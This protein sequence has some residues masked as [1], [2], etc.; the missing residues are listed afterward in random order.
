[1]GG[2]S[3]FIRPHAPRRT[4]LASPSIT[5]RWSNKWCLAAPRRE[6]WT[7]PQ[8]SDENAQK[9]KIKNEQ[10]PKTGAARL[11]S[12]IVRS[13]DSELRKKTSNLP[14]CARTQASV[15]VPAPPCFPSPSFPLP[16]CPLQLPQDFHGA[17]I[18]CRRA[19]QACIMQRPSRLRINLFGQ[20]RFP[21]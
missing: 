8:T 2:R 19:V 16:F 6:F 12:W 7:I 14:V 4:D 10:I 9:V 17:S 1:M 15:P 13:S 3:F 5:A 11:N 18:D 20:T 21:N